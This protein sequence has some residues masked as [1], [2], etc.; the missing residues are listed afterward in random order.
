MKFW[1]Q[2]YAAIGFDPRWKNYEDSLIKYVQ[3]VGRPDTKVDVYGI[4]KRAPRIAESDY[5]QYLHV[6]QVIDKGLQAEREGYDAFVVGGTYDPGA[7]Y[8]REVLDIPVACIAESS[9]HMACMLAPKFTLIAT[10]EAILNRQ[11]RLVKQY[12]LEQRFVPGAHIGTENTIQ[13]VDDMAK[14]PGEI[15]NKVTGTARKL[16]EQGAGALVPGFGGLTSFLAEHGIRDID[17]VPIV[18]GVAV[19]IKTA[20]MLVDLKNMGIMRTKKGLDV[21]PVS[22][23]ELIAARKIYGLE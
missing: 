1:Y 21:S 6:S 11:T 3:N 15:I 22:K 20:E 12:G 23:E 10:G 8:L 2:S 19:V 18:D 7:V 16:I 17:G 5:I 14:N 13:Y 9:F 4:E